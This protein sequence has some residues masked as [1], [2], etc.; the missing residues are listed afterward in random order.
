MEY[1]PASSRS[2]ARATHGAERV[3][4]QHLVV[5]FRVKHTAAGVVTR[6]TARVTYADTGVGVGGGCCGDCCGV[7]EGGG[8]DGGGGKRGSF[9]F[10]DPCLC[11]I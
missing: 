6:V 4:T 2:Q 5:V 8:S 11:I 9:V 7:G 3:I 1:L 10:M